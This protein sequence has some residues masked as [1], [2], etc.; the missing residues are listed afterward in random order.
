[1]ANLGEGVEEKRGRRQGRVC[2][3]WYWSPLRGS[4]SSGQG[5]DDGEGCSVCWP[6]KMA[7]GF[8]RRRLLLLPVEREDSE[9]NTGRGGC[10]V[11]VRRGS[12][13]DGRGGTSG[14]ASAGGESGVRLKSKSAR[15][16]EAG[17]AMLNGVVRLQIC[18]APFC[19]FSLEEVERLTTLST[20]AMWLMILGTPL[21]S[22]LPSQWT[23]CELNRPQSSTKG[24]FLG[25]AE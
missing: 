23:I 24:L 12:G 5:Q 20:S 15:S 4:T 22:F 7:V 16:D 6:T 17:V 11:G 14:G 13:V 2:W 10:G 1:V 21:A 8:L 25:Q 9:R 18:A 3:D 19:C